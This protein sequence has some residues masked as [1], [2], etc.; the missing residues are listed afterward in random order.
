MSSCRT[1][2]S[3]PHKRSSIVNAPPSCVFCDSVIDNANS[4]NVIMKIMLTNIINPFLRRAYEMKLVRLEHIH[5]LIVKWEQ[6][7]SS[8]SS[9]SSIK[10]TSA[11]QSAVIKEFKIDKLSSRA[12]KGD[13][14]GDFSC[15]LLSDK[16]KLDDPS[17]PSNSQLL[18]RVSK[19]DQINMIP[20]CMYLQRIPKVSNIERR[21]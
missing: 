8:L 3:G 18:P 17:C 12:S 9:G 5:S 11:Y 6:I 4:I 10:R 19:S 13:V 2:S 20:V 14:K 16:I 21:N 15:D 1:P 7:E